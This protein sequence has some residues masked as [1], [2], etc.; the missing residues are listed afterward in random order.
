MKLRRGD[1][2]RIR[3]ERTT[4]AEIEKIDHEK[5]LF[6][7]RFLGDPVHIIGEEFQ[8]MFFLEDELGKGSLLEAKM[9]RVR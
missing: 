3:W 5:K 4:W 9:E 6:L 1:I 8:T 7:V 2:V